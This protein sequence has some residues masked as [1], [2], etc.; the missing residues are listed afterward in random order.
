MKRVAL[1]P[2]AVA[3]LVLA[4]CGSSGSTTSGKAPSSVMAAAKKKLDSTSGVEIALSA[5][6]DPGSDYLKSAEGTIVAKP[7]AFDG[8]IS[9]RISGIQAS[10]IHVISAGGTLWV[11]APILGWTDNYQPKQLCAPD[12]ATLL[13]PDSGVSDLLT[14]ATGLTAGSAERD[15]NDASVVTTPY[16]GKESGDAIRQILPCAK[17]DSFGVTFAI[18]SDG[19]LRSAKLTGS[20]FPGASSITYTIDI[21]KYDVTKDIKAPK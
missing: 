6:G 18:A 19:S 17:G 20:F 4:G 2:L 10:D 5:S 3:A 16:S 15:T 14:S 7:P 8:K 12:P 21:T 11:D 9:G 13:N 1:V